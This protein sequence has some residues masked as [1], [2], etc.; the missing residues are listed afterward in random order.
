MFVG[1][2]GGELA[3]GGAGEGPVAVVDEAVMGSAQQGEVVQAGV[4]AVRPVDQVV[5]VGEL[6]WLVAAGE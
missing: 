3:G 2:G 1:A 6:G 4:P 5:G